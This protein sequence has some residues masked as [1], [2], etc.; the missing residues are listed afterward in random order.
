MTPLWTGEAVAAATGGAL[1]APFEVDGVAFD[2]RE[3]VG[4]ELFVAMRGAEADGHRFVASAAERGA[5]GFIVEQA[6]AQPHVLVGDSFVALEKLGVAA[7]ARTDAT[8]IGVTGSV[9]KTGTKE[10]LR[11]AF[12]RIAPDATHA[13]VKSYNNH[14]GVPLSLSRMPAA[15]RFGVFEMG[16]NHAGEIA[17]LTRMVRPHVAVVTWVGGSH[18]EH[19]ADGEVG[20]A[21][22]KAEIFEGVEPGGWAVWPYD[23]AHAAILKAAIE[24][25]GLQSLSFGWSADAD[26]HVLRADIGAA[27]TELVADV[28]GEEVHCRIGMAGRHWVSNA[29]AVL[30]AVKAAGGDLAEAGLALAGL[31]GLPGRGARHSLPVAGGE[32]VLIDESYNANPVSMAAALAVLR[33]VPAKRRIAVLGAM[34]ELGRETQAMHEALGAPIAEAGISELALV[35]PEMLALKLD[36]AVHLPD[37][38]AATAWTRAILQEGD[39][40]LVKGSNSVGL[41]GLVAELRRS[42]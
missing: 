2:S 14:T 36:G 5:A 13:S 24:K 17:A 15:T 6:V 19:F 32:A 37:A 3:I 42:A 22:A 30:A 27:G 34:R 8:V 39:V 23:N 10:A 7:R 16:M 20:I 11:L 28:A 41:G 9:G 25:A 40:L 33:D 29:L 4:G 35:G 38:A 1:S 26:V 18:V 12:E 31:T 21:R